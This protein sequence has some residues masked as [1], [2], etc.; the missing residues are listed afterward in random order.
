MNRIKYFIPIAVAAIS[1]FS[2]AKTSTSTTTDGNFIKQSDFTVPRTKA[3]SFTI[4][5]TV[6]ITTGYN[7]ANNNAR[8]KDLWHYD[9]T[10]DTW[11]QGADFIGIARN[12]AT[13]F[14][15]GNK[16]YVGTGYDGN[17]YLRDFYEYNPSTGSWTQIKDFP[18]NPRFDAVGFGIGNFG[19]LGT[20]TDST[21]ADTRDMWKYDPSL[22]SWTAIAAVPGSSRSA[23]VAFVYNNKGYIVTGKNNGN[24]SSLNDFA[25]F[26]PSTG[27]WSTLRK[28]T[29]ISTDNYD[30]NYT[31][32][33]R[34]DAVAFVLDKYA[35]IT[36][37]T[38]ASYLSNTWRYDFSNDTWKEV[39]PWESTKPLRKGA[40]AYTL[41][42]RA[43]IATGQSSS[44]FL[45]DVIEFAP[46]QQYNAND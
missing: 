16:A 12:S 22:D 19:Y 30:D 29:N 34:S 28:I 36:T 1:I 26:D 2:C 27:A 4:G 35:Y 41:N 42:G 7:S 44:Q 17:N 6:Y 45:N 18:A 38:N 40:V 43:F 14:T 8:L 3:V 25:S 10:T 15:V 46:N 24:A 13:S 21:G 31:T 5:D 33:T 37:G 9:I 39:T 11:Y 20:G 23:S 32:I